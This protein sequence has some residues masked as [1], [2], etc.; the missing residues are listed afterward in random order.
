M[1]IQRILELGSSA[2]SGSFRGKKQQHS[3]KEDHPG[4]CLDAQTRE[5]NKKAGKIQFKRRGTIESIIIQD[6]VRCVYRSSLNDGAM[7]EGNVTT[8]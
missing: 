1:H 3:M 6:L 5:Q 4:Q 7:Q 8:T 2:F